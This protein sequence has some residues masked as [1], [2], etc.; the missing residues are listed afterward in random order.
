MTKTGFISSPFNRWTV[1]K[2]TSIKLRKTLESVKHRLRPLVGLRFRPGILPW[3]W[4]CRCS[5]WSD[6]D[7]GFSASSRAQRPRTPARTHRQ[8]AADYRRH[9]WAASSLIPDPELSGQTRTYAA[10]GDPWRVH[11]PWE[12]CTCRP[13]WR[14]IHFPA[15]SCD[16]STSNEKLRWIRRLGKVSEKSFLYCLSLI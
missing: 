13:L 16:I 5:P 4:L 3:S 2:S 14:R 15:V 9:R 6:P 12:M 1:S 8:T 10:L 11:G 7:P